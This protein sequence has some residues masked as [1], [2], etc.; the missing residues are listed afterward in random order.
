V[1]SASTTSTSST[2]IRTKFYRSSLP[3]DLVDRPR[4]IDQIN[5]GLDRPLTLV[6]APAGYGKSVLVSSW[7]NSC[8]R[9]SAWLTLDESIDDLG[10][11]LAYFV[12]AIQTIFPGALQRTQALLTAVSLPPIGVLAGSLINELDELERDFVM[13]LDDYHT[14][15]KQE[16]H[17]LLNAL[18][19]PPAKHMHLVLITRKDPPLPHSVLLAR[20]QMNEVRLS[21]LR[22]SADEIATFMR[23]TLGSPLPAEAIAALAEQTEGWITSLRL[24]AVT[25]RYSPD[26]NSRIAELRALE[27]NR[28]LTDYLMNEVLAQTPPEIADFLLKT[29]ILDR[30]CGPLCEALLGHEALEDSDQTPL[31][32]LEQ[33]N[34]FT[35]S[36]DSERR[37]YRYHHLFRGFLQNRLERRHDAGEIAQLHARTSAWFAGQGLLEEALQ[38][39]LLGH[40]TP[41]AVRLMAEHRHA[42]MDSEQ[43]Q[44]HERTFRMFP[45]ETVAQHPDLLLMAAWK[46]RLAGFNAAYVLDLLDRAEGLIAQRTL[47]GEHAMHLRGEIDT[48]RAIMAYEAATDPKNVIALAERALATTPRAWYYV[49]SSAWLYMA[50]A[51]QMAGRLDQAY[52]VVAEGEPEDVAQ[53][54]AVRARVVAANCF[55]EW[56]AGDLPAMLQGAAHLVAVG[57]THHRTESLGWAHY[58]LASAAYQRDDLAAAEAHARVVEEIRYLGRPMAYL[59]SAFIYASIFQARGLPEQARQKLDLAFDFI[60]ETRSDGLV[61]LA[62]AFRG[63][64]AV[65]QGDLGAA[66]HWATKFGSHVPLT[67]LSYFY[68]PQLALPKILLAQDT[69]ASRELAAEALSRLHAFVTSIHNTRFTIE[70]L[71]LEALLYH[72]QGNEHRALEVL[73]QAVNLAQPGGFVRVF[74][75]LG[76]NMADLLGRLA[77]KGVARDYVERI[78]RAFPEQ[79]AGH[80]LQLAMPPPAQAA[81]IEPLTRRELEVLA[82]L[83]QRMTAREIAQK[84][85]LSDQTVKRHRAN[86]Y[87]KFGVHS[88]RDAIAA[89]GAH[90]ILSAASPSD[91]LK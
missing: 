9:P 41:A 8:E 88:R 55:I 90:S 68:A 61:P 4:L 87:Q 57:E 69:P 75:D 85:V 14:G 45:A 63:E 66:S 77:A 71:A 48:L 19:Q 43:W 47:Q 32:W 86:I 23:N 10:V 30:M 34:L 59:Q 52:A 24:A 56:M 33:N 83:A 72:A 78:L 6:S 25:L 3:S 11:F 29:A 70:V 35:V 27:R 50:T 80:Q 13:V 81:M 74:V 51:Y 53:N 79:H 22:F 39:A 46:A 1:K 84:L 28:N 38:H 91:P 89:A 12:N 40:D 2:L 20:N 16:I 31:E 82:L 44:L 26:A 60:R 18:L 73:E 65:L 21:E 64:L 58:L 37:W 49:R 7:L 67:A 42:L 76:P 62:Q 17:D 5:R 15:H 36:M 54:G